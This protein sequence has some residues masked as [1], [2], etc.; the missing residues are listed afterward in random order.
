[1][2]NGAVC[3][4]DMSLGNQ[5]H[6][7]RAL[8]GRATFCGAVNSPCLDEVSPYQFTTVEK[9]FRV[10]SVRFSGEHRLPACKSRQLA[11][12]VFNRS[13]NTPECC[14]QAA[15]NRGLAA[16]PQNGRPAFTARTPR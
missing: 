13:V 8:N 4:M 11:E 16:R 9:Y 7:F 10:A 2:R 15:G 12:T 1:M 6:C 3:R 5:S 14:R